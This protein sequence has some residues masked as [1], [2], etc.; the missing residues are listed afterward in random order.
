MNPAGPDADRILVTGATGFI[1]AAVTRAL[2]RHGYRVRVLVRSGARTDNIDGL[3]VERVQGDL[4]RP[5]SLAAALDNCDGLIHAAADY[6]LWSLDC[7]P[8]YRTNVDGTVALLAAAR[9]S[10]VRRIVYTSSVAVLGSGADGGGVDET[11][12]ASLAEMTGHYKRS[13]WLAE[14]RV[15][16]MADDG[17]PVVLVQPSAP[18]GPRDIKPTPTGRIILDTLMG[19]MPAY[20]NTGLNV[21]HVDDVA[22]GHVLALQHGI[23]G[24]RYILGSEN[25]ELREILEK[26]CARC[27]RRS[28]RLRLPHLAVA[29]I[30]AACEVLARVTGQ[31][32]RVSLESARMA[33]SQMYFSSAR[34]RREL[35]FRARPAVE[36]INDAVDWFVGQGVSS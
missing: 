26:T 28:P 2:L 4:C 29:P 35:G 34:A 7:R 33:K 3:A 27:G 23:P 30:A 25:M 11:R 10:G 36:A 21:V 12:V 1:G 31:P 5:E 18:L 16:A 17:L 9:A 22:E 6:R 13:K 20:V 14:Q 19:R 32:P 8:I 24:R 15:T